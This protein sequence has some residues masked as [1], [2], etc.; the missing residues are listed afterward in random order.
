MNNYFYKD[1][2]LSNI[3]EG[4]EGSRFKKDYKKGVDQDE[5]RRR[6]SE[7]TIQL[8]KDKKDDQLSKRRQ[9]TAPV[10]IFIYIYIFFII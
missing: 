5:A 7:T 4:G 9:S 10:S 6:R 2:A 3:M 8:R 1:I